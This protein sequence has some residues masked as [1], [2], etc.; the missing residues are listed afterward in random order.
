MPKQ[1]ILQIMPAADWGASYADD[2]PDQEQVVPLIGWALVQE[3]GGGTAVVGL[4]AG[5]EVELADARPHFAGY[6]YIA[7]MFVDDYDP[8]A[9][10][11]ADF[12]DDDEVGSEL[13][14]GDEGPPFDPKTG[15]LN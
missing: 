11:E 6:V 7:D 9:F 15:L 5:D 13:E 14:D 8:E 4:V 1:K 3:A 2:D 12:E 10:D